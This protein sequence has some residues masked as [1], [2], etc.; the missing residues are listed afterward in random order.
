MRTHS[1]Y[2]EELAG[3]TPFRGLWRRDLLEIAR[4]VD[5][6]DVDAGTLI[7]ERGRRGHELFLVVAG[8]AT[9][10]EDGCPTAMV[11]PSDT[12]GEVAVIAGAPHPATVTAASPMRLM[13]I[14]RRELLGL[15]KAVPALGQHLLRGMAERLGKVDGASTVGP[16]VSQEVADDPGQTLEPRRPLRA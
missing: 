16:R 7:V 8:S 13:V 14:R 15:L 12:I 4:S 5:L 9:V 2:L 3:I 10:D 1:D 11:G 6:V